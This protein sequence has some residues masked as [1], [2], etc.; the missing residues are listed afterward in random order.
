MTSNSQQPAS[1]PN[2]DNFKPLL[3]ERGELKQILDAAEARIKQL[4]ADLRPVLEGRG[5]IIAEG[6]SFNCKL[7]KGR[8]SI[9]KELLEEFLKKH[10]LSVADFEKEGAPFTTFS[11]KPVNV[12]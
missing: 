7:S 12:L 9:D 6:F 11:V 2:L 1:S 4:D 8:K 5:E 10:G 3:K